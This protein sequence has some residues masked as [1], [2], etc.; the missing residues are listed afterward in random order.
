MFR[1][2]KHQATSKPSAFLSAHSRRY[3][4]DMCM[5]VSSAL[6]D[7]EHVTQHPYVENCKC[8]VYVSFSVARLVKL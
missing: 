3:S 8:H 1:R 7:S 4:A 2:K 5:S 6:R